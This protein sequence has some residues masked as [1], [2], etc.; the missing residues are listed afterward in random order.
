[1][2]KYSSG[3]SFTAMT[4]CHP[5]GTDP[6]KTNK[7]LGQPKPLRQT[8]TFS[9][10]RKGNGSGQ[11]GRMTGAPAAATATITC[12]QANVTPGT[13]VIRVGAYELRPAVDFAVGAGDNALADNL[14]AAIDALPGFSSP[15]PAAN[16]LVIS[17]TNGHGDDTRIEVVEWGA[18]SAFALTST[19]REG[20][21]DS[22][23]P[24]PGAPVL[25]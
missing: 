8:F 5:F 2:S 9:W 23:A 3:P 16:V 18:A 15:N 12:T 25:A 20:Y 7:L 19:D 10:I 11:V 17:T 6:S 21:M 4:P 13:H 24:S 22:G 14:A 1:M